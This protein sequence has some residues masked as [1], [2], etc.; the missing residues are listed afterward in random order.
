MKKLVIVG[1]G[2]IGGSMAIASKGFEDYEVIGVDISQPTIRFAAEHGV[3][4][5]VTEDLQILSRADITMLC[6]HP[7]GI[8][9]FLREHKNDF[10]PGSLVTDVCGIKMSDKTNM[11]IA[12]LTVIGV[13]ILGVIFASDP[14][15]S[16]FRVVS[17][18]WAGFGATFGPVMLFGL[19]WKRCNKYGAIAGMLTGAVMIFVWKFLVAPLGGILN[20]YELMPAFI[21]SSIAIV[22]VSLCTKAPE[23][24]IVAEFESIGK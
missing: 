17:F 3:A 23:A 7:E 20:I 18:A 24:E 8:V 12:R 22:V 13:A 19:F 2:L 4:D 16:I 10:K 9:R 21:L 14:N 15:S 6:L 5:R 1:L 11:L